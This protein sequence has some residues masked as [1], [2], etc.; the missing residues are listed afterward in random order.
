MPEDL[1]KIIAKDETKQQQIREKTTKDAVNVAA[2]SITGTAAGGAGVGIGAG[3]RV[4]VPVGAAANVA[5]KVVALAAPTN[6]SPPN[7]SGANAVAASAT[8]SPLIANATSTAISTSGPLASTTTATA[9][10]RTRIPMV[11]S[12]I[13]PFNP[14]KL[15]GPAAIALAEKEKKEKET[16]AVAATPSDVSSSVSATATG[17]A[18][19]PKLNINAPAFK[20]KVGAPAFK[21]SV[22]CLYTMSSSHF[23]YRLD[24]D[25]H[26]VA[27]TAIS[28]DPVKSS[29]IISIFREPLLWYSCHQKGC[30]SSC[31]GRFQS[32]QKQHSWRERCRSL[33][34]L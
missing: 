31:Q 19:L 12:A 9:P 8:T 7:N 2:R 22:R 32:V 33:D 16:L 18:S 20:L 14:Q 17:N 25:N 30:C 27:L 11:I 28:F 26:I 23:L 24:T 6:A 29:N 5:K 4:V 13:P 1:L 15:R 34:C 21:P 3:P 10:K